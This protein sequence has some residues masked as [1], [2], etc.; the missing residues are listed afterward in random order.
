[1]LRML[2]QLALAGKHLRWTPRDGVGHC[3]P[4]CACSATRL[5]LAS[6]CVENCVTVLAA[7]CP[8]A[9]MLCMLCHLPLVG[10]HLRWRCC[11][12]FA[13]VCP[14]APLL[15]MLYQLAVA[16]KHL[17]CKPP[18]GVGHCLP[19]CPPAV[20][21]VPPGFGWQAFALEMLSCIRPCLPCCSSAV[22]VVPAGCS[23]EA[24]ALET[25][26]LRWPLPDCASMLRSR[27]EPGTHGKQASCT[28]P[29]Y[30]RPCRPCCNLA[31]PVLTAAYH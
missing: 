17:R 5:W 31:V 30:V 20:H 14:A 19:C 2:Y 18:S 13:P 3:L 24:F 26:A 29:R 22:H 6:I 11:N 1:M 4:C 21:V 16:G 23:W 9:P 25:T 10:K 7:A 15:C 12:A 27:H 8:A 28:A